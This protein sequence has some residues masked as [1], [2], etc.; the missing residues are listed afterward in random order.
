MNTITPSSF[1]QF[2]LAFYKTELVQSTLIY[3]QNEFNVNVNLALLCAMLNKKKVYLTELQLLRL[4]QTVS[5]FSKQFTQPLRA[6][7]STYKNKKDVVS[8][9]SQLRKKLLDAE[10]LFEQQEQAILITELT[11]LIADN[12]LINNVNI[13]NLA[14]YEAL[15]YKS[16]L[17]KQ[18]L[19]KQEL[20]TNNQQLSTQEMKLTDLNQ[21]L[22]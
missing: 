19:Y 11:K 2:S 16:V 22:F 15:L 3:F 13:D 18:Y 20:N 6:L 1:W 4:Q 9:Y 10:L 12:A 5:D 21:Y 8:E 17:S 7:R 14:L